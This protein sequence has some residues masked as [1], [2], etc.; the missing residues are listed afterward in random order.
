[1]NAMNVTVERHQILEAHPA[2]E[3]FPMMNAEEFYA[4]KS[5]MTVNGLIEPIWL[6]EDK[7]LD[8]RNRYKACRELNIKPDFRIYTQSDPIAFVVSLNLQRRHLNSSQ[9]AL[10]AAGLANLT[11]GCHPQSSANLQSLSRL[12]AANLLNVSERSTNTAKKVQTKGIPLLTALVE[13]GRLSVSA[14]SEIAELSQEQQTTI[15]AM[16]DNAILEAAKDIRAEKSVVRE[17]HDFYA[18]DPATIEPLIDK[19]AEYQETI[20]PVVWENAC[21]ENHLANKLKEFGFEVMSSDIVKRQSDVMEIDFLNYNNQSVDIRS[22][23]SNI[24]DNKIDILTNPPY[25]T[26]D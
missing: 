17:E 13:Q 4:L 24:E 12:Q 9:R 6:Y 15:L 2:S 19:L 21:G 23:V 16:D 5:D 7:I 3:I 8:G 26:C 11:N 25:K 1:M 14:A 10:I 20:N 22:L 18:T